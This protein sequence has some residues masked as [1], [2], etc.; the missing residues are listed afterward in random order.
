MQLEGRRDGEMRSVL[1]REELDRQA[2]I[3][4]AKWIAVGQQATFVEAFAIE[5]GDESLRRF[6]DIRIRGEAPSG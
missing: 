5:G 3:D 2:G 1:R 4:D 6:Q